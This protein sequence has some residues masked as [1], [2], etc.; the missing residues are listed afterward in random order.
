MSVLTAVSAWR[1]GPIGHDTADPL[2][3][4]SVSGARA[5]ERRYES[6]SAREAEGPPSRFL[7]APACG[8]SGL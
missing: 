8:S 6:C 5:G 3:Q 1:P 2:N 4:R 7:S